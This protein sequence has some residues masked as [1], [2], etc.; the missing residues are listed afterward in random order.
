MT[1]APRLDRL[2]QQLAEKGID[3]A[4]VQSGFN[5]RYLTGFTG[6]DGTLLVGPA[7]AY[8]LVDFRYTEQAQQQTAGIE[9]VEAGGSAGKKPLLTV[10]RELLASMGADRIGLEGNHLTFEQYSDLTQ[11][12]TGLEPV[13]IGGVVEGLRAVKD[14]AELVIMRRAAAITDAAFDHILGYLEPGLRESEVALE[15]EYFLRRQG[16]EGRSFDFIVASGP[17]SAMPHGVATD[18]VLQ[19]GELVTL[20]YGCIYQ[21]YCSDMTRTVLLGEPDDKQREVYAVV[22]AAQRAGVAGIRPGMMGREADAICREVIAA[23]GYGE[24]FGHGTGH[25]VGLEIHEEPGVGSRSTR[26]LE[27]G[28]VITVEPGVYL[29]GWGGVRIEDSAVVTATG[30]EVMSHAPKELIILE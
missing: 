8:L 28:N 29:A 13:S 17:R 3:A 2:R 15:L 7:A 6:T 19:P 21:G 24:Y 16:A 30:I 23:L 10:V 5:R 26:I 14:E 25:G 12:L 27:P 1:T 22:L 4:L 9:V 18:K 20:D 11:Q